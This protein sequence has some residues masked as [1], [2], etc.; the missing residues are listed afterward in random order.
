MK[1]KLL[2]TSGILIAMLILFIGLIFVVNLTIEYR[3]PVGLSNNLLVYG[4]LDFAGAEGTMVVEGHRSG[5]PIQTSKIYCYSDIKRCFAATA[6]LDPFKFMN[7]ELTDYPVTEW[8]DNHLVISEDAGCVTNTY[9]INWVTKSVTGIRVKKRKVQQE[10]DCTAILHDELR[11]TMRGGF[12]VWQE[13]QRRA[14]PAY[15][16]VIAAFLW[17]EEKR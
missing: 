8:T 13:E 2:I 12:E 4:N 6:S 10:L 7:V 15:Y 16:E 5:T 11:M 9:T 1:R 14:W 3:V 17:D